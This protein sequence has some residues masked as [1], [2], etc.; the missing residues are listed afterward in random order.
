MLPVFHNLFLRS[1]STESD[2]VGSPRSGIFD[3]S[4]ERNCDNSGSSMCQAFA[5]G[6]LGGGNSNIFYFPS[7]FG[8]DSHFD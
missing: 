4:S 6:G 1:L 5:K 3:G 2:H 7:L 8:E